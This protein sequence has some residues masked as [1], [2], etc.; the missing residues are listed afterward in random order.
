MATVKVTEDTFPD[1]VA[2]FI[3]DYIMSDDMVIDNEKWEYFIDILHGKGLKTEL[4]KYYIATN[5]NEKSRYKEI[6]RIFRK[7]G[8]GRKATIN[9]VNQDDR[10]K[11]DVKKD[12][13][14]KTIVKKALKAVTEHKKKYYNMPLTESKED[15]IIHKVMNESKEE[16]IL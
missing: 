12:S 1:I 10:K 6:K 13:V 14:I 16:G 5:A 8:K 3:L 7:E 15:D 9:I 11:S 4:V 2:L